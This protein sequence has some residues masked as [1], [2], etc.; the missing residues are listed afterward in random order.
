L[1]GAQKMK[2]KFK[3]GDNVVC[4]GRRNSRL[5]NGAGWEAGLK[6]VVTEITF[7]E[8]RKEYIYWKGLGHCGVYEKYIGYA[9][10]NVWKGAKR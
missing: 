1:E 6:F 9:I 2:A 3:L 10:T 7:D 4:I 8:A 5:E